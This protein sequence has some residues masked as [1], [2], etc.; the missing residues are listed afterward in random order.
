[1]PIPRKTALTLTDIR[2]S[3]GTPFRTAREHEEALSLIRRLAVSA[4][5][6]SADQAPSAV[7][8]EALTGGRSAARVFKLTPFFGPGRQA[9]GPPVVVK[10]TSHAEGA[11][12]KA[13][14]DKFVRRALP[15]ACRPDLLAFGR[16]RAYS[17]LC[18]SF[19]GRAKG[20][21]IDTLTD[22][23]QRG[24]A[25]KVELVL[26]RIFAPLRDTWYSPARFRAERDIARRYLDRYFTGPRSTA[27]AEATLRACAARYFN[28]RQKNGRYVIGGLSFPSPR[29]LLFASGRER[30]YR[31]CILHG[32]LNSDNIVVTDDPAGVTV[33][34]F[35]KTGRGH[36]HEDLIHIEGSVRINYCRDTLVPRQLGPEAGCRETDA[37]RYPVRDASFGE[38]LEK[39]RLIALGREPPGNDPYSAAIRKIR[40]TAFRYFGRVDDHANYHFAVAAIGLRLMQIVDL[41]HAARARITAST[42]WA[43]KVLAGEL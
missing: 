37:D 36:V 10:I 33:V 16:T 26:R 9:K 17:G 34:D 4:G 43:A 41:S 39:E 1:M 5:L 25:T 19:A 12:E 29:A 18:Y 6:S 27:E 24:D 13:N 31:S 23:L 40:R 20:S 32:D 11:S 42:L 14:Y 7:T 38:I 30:P 28:A 21:G 15:A 2:F 35:Q 3:G 22:C 8:L